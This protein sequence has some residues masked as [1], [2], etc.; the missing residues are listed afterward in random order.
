MRE[1]YEIRVL[2]RLGPALRAAFTAMRWEVTSHQ[3]VIR[4][5]LSRHELHQLLE[6]MDRSGVLVVDLYRSRS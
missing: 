3:T 1:S 4:G 6:A 5:N 2:G